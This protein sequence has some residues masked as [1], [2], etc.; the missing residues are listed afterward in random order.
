MLEQ[1]ITRIGNAVGDWLYVIAGGL[2]FAE[3]A[4][5][6]GMVL[7]GETALLVAGVFCQRGVLNLWIMIVVAVI[8]A[9]VGDS[10]GFEF[11]RKFGPSLR[12]SRLGR[13]V[14]EG[15]WS[16]VDQFLH[17]HGGKAIF[18]GR[19]TAVLRALVPSMAG[20]SGMHYPTFFRWNAAGGIL[21]ATGCVLLGY[22]FSSALATV[23]RYLTWAPLAVLALVI[24]GYVALHL[25]RRRKEAV[26]ERAV[27]QVR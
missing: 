24:A 12:A 27:E 9:I 25:R 13:R 10:V 17:R 15:R 23:S 21:W 22:A 3:A 1:V 19:L 14:G 8:C 6:I 11:G 5:L 2:A 18:L 26:A 4:I 20:M 16:T 7:P